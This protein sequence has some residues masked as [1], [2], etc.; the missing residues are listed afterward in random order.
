MLRSFVLTACTLAIFACSAQQQP[1]IR[2][3][4]AS[5]SQVQRQ[6]P[7]EISKELPVADPAKHPAGLL[8]DAMRPL[9]SPMPDRAQDDAMYI[10]Y[11]TPN[12]RPRTASD[13]PPKG[14]RLA[15]AKAMLRAYPN[16]GK[17]LI[18]LSKMPLKRERLR[19]RGYPAFGPICEFLMLKAAVD[20]DEHRS[21]DVEDDLFAMVQLAYLSDRSLRDEG[22]FSGPYYAPN[23]IMYVIPQLRLAMA[24]GLVD[25]K[26]RAD[27]LKKLPTVPSTDWWAIDAINIQLHNRL[28]VLTKPTLDPIVTQYEGR[29]VNLDGPATVALLTGIAKEAIDAARLPGTPKATTIEDNVRKSNPRLFPPQELNAHHPPDDATEHETA[30]YTKLL[31]RTP[32]STGL[33]WAMTF[34]DETQGTLKNSRQIWKSWADLR[35]VLKKG[36]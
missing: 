27:I 20:A 9:T 14:K 15:K 17:T 36:S 33:R 30:E 8:L 35:E 4:Q 19:T 25:H 18:R 7:A 23:D 24:W 11:G 1:S 2:Y 6:V 3:V 22:R 21:R 16:V 28:S 32:N 34:V 31:M 13:G 12:L 29:L 10:G 5:Q 26:G